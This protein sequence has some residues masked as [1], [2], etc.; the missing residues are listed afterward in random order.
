VLRSGNTRSCGCLKTEVRRKPIVDGEVVKIPLTRGKVAVV[1]LVDGDLG[2]INWNAQ[3]G[4]VTWY[5]TRSIGKKSPKGR[6]HQFLHRVIADRIGLPRE[7]LPDHKDGDGL[8]CRRNNLREATPSQNTQNSRLRTDNKT[9]FKGVSWSPSRRGYLAKIRANGER[10]VLGL[11]RTAE[12][13]SAAYERAAES[14]HGEFRRRHPEI[15][16]DEQGAAW[17]PEETRA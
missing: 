1:D 6:H 12:E 7:L 9:G 15:I 10:H 16:V 5:A 13:A 14:L 17:W 3:K 11:F 8:N 4:T 2:L